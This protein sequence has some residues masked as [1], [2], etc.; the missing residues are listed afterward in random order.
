MYSQSVDMYIESAC[1]C[2][3]VKLM[4]ICWQYSPSS[5]PAFEEILA[6]LPAVD[7]YEAAV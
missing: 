4:D 2:A 5:R 3:S 7:G 6:E 1:S